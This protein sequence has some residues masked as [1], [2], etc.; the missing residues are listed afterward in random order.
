M[1][2]IVYTLDVIKENIKKIN[3]HLQTCENMKMM[4]IIDGGKEKYE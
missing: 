4:L 1:K 2:E 3:F